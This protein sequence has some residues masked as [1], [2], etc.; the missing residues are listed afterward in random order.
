MPYIN[1]WAAL[2][3]E[4][5]AALACRT[6]AAVASPPIV[7]AKMLT[8]SLIALHSMTPPYRSR[9]GALSFSATEGGI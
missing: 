6:C 7:N 1:V 3:A 5:H 4:L 2:G 8:A 9:F